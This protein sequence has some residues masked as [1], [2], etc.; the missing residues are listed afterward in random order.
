MNTKE[1]NEPIDLGIFLKQAIAEFY[2]DNSEDS[3]LTVMAILT[4]CPVFVPCHLFGKEDEHPEAYLSQDDALLEPEVLPNGDNQYYLAFSSRDEMG[5][6]G[7]DF[8]TVQCQFMQLVTVAKAHKADL[9]G[10]VVNVFNEPLALSWD[11]LEVLE[12]MMP[13]PGDYQYM[14]PEDS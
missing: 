4:D 9:S 10:I 6:Y 3:L 12:S 14:K 7:R 2:E 8:L 13:I 1:P 5:E 11:L